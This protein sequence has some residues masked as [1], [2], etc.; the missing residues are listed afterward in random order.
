MYWLFDQFHGAGLAIPEAMWAPH[1]K[2]MVLAKH[3][4]QRYIGSSSTQKKQIL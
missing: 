4:K 3:S 2:L 1:S